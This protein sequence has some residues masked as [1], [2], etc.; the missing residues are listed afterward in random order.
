MKFLASF[1]ILF[2]LVPSFVV[3]AEPLNYRLYSD[4]SLTIYI[5]PSFDND[6][7]ITTSSVMGYYQGTYP[8]LTDTDGTITGGITE[9][10]GSWIQSFWD[11]NYDP[12]SGT[13]VYTTFSPNTKPSDETFI[14]W[15]LNSHEYYTDS[16]EVNDFGDCE[17][18]SYGSEFTFNG[19]YLS[20]FIDATA[21]G[22]STALSFD[23]D[24]F[25]NLS[26]LTTSD[27]PDAIQVYITTS[28]DS[29]V[30][31][32]NK[33]ILPLNDG[34]A[35]TTITI[36]DHHLSSGQTYPLPDGTYT[37][38]LKFWHILHGTYTLNEAEI[39][40]NFEIESGLVTG[41]E[42][43]NQSDGR[44][45]GEPECSLT[46]PADCVVALARFLFVP[47]EA[48]LQFVQRQFSSSTVPMVSEAYAGFAAVTQAVENSDASAATSSLAYRFQLPEYGIDVEMFSVDTMTHL[49]GGSQS[50]FRAIIEVVMYLGFLSMVVASIN[51]ALSVTHTDIRVRQRNV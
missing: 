18:S 41:S 16:L 6:D 42:V 38:W 31:L 19:T 1:F 8:D 36:E 37:A 49:M 25:I 17:P 22:S 2:L 34:N 48:A 46:R 28:D 21:T 33:L 26:E 9:T 51:N 40:V 23:V 35:S 4:C 5:P 30:A 44:I 32:R 27:R 11:S 10:F 43:V 14:Y 24:Y 3:A 39:T 20:R 13:T 45:P 15:K 29:Q 12:E 7:V 47:D 50:T